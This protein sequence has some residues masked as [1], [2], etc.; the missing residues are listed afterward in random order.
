MIIFIV[1]LLRTCYDY[2]LSIARLPYYSNMKS[3][4]ACS[5]DHWVSGEHSVSVVLIPCFPAIAPYIMGH[6]V[7]RGRDNPIESSGL[8]SLSVG[9]VDI[10]FYG[11]Q[12]LFLLFLSNIH[13][14]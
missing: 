13:H 11:R 2:M 1:I 14:A 5:N 3:Y 7:D 10:Y 8:H 12:A 9:L 4:S 6:V